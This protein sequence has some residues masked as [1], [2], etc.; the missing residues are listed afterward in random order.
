MGNIN[1]IIMVIMQH[2]TVKIYMRIINIFNYIYIDGI[3]NNKFE[4]YIQIYFY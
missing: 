1:H 3:L 2:E 4:Y